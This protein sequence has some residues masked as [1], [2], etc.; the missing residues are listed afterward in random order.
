MTDF[1]QNLRDKG[2]T[3]AEIWA[4]YGRLIDALK[5]MA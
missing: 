5:E 2:L 4:G 1:D 3:D